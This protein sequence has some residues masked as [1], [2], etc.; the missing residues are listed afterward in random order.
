MNQRTVVAL[1]MDPLDTLFFRD[2]RP[3]GASNRVV[4]Q[5]P[6]PQTLAGAL[7]TGLLAA[8]GFDLDK[9]RNCC[10][11]RDLRDLADLQRLLVE[12]CQAE[13]WIVNAQFRGPWLA[14]RNPKNRRNV[15]PLLPTPATLFR[16]LPKDGGPAVWVEA[17]PDQQVM[18]CYGDA[19]AGDLIPLWRKAQTEDQSEAKYPGG[20]F[21]P[22]AIQQFLAGESIDTAAAC[23][24]SNWFRDDE[25]FGGDRRTGIGVDMN[26]LTAADSQIY[27]IELTA[28]KGQVERRCKVTQDY[29]GWEICLYA[30]VL[31]GP[32]ESTKSV[33]CYLEDSPIAFGGEG[34]YVTAN[35]VEAYQW[36]L[37]AGSDGPAKWLLASHGI[38]GGL[39]GEPCWRPN[40]LRQDGV[41]RA[42]ASS[43]PVA[44]SG[45]DNVR[46]GPR[47][48]RFAV[49]AGSVYFTD[50]RVELQ[51]DSLCEWGPKDFT[52]TQVAEEQ[53]NI[54]QG[55]GFALRGVWK[56]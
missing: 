24:E 31:A 3:F 45:W 54:T 16:H 33:E 8:S 40:A 10:R 7:R 26:R 39:D 38:F 29:D 30:E 9:F 36:Q 32:V 2:G 1:T 48:T 6:T 52:G 20:L 25:L 34:R 27:G 5:L 49:P 12:E 53:E 23:Y 28:L 43:T 44:V 56:R 47:P 41:L 50:G 18:A 13:P 22:P 17:L 15:L 46:G 14:L 35:A 37:P 11:A 55:W 42:A 19:G 51:H 4:G 21:A